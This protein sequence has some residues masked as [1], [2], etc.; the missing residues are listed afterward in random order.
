MVSGA[1]EGGANTFPLQNLNVPDEGV[2]DMCTLSYL[3]VRLMLRLM[4]DTIDTTVTGSVVH[5]SIAL[6]L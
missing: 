5:A 2:E 3:H 1:Q 4:H 6:L